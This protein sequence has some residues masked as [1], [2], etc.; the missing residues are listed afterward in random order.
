MYLHGYKNDSILNTKTSREK[1]SCGAVITKPRNEVSA[2]NA[3]K[4]LFSDIEYL[5]FI[6]LSFF[7]W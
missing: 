7:L 1:N 6:S 3:M 4:Y 5:M 2:G